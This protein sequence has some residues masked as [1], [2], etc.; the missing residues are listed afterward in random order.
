MTWTPSIYL[1]P[2]ALHTMSPTMPRSV[3]TTATISSCRTYLWLSLPLWREVCLSPLRTVSLPMQ[4]RLSVLHCIPALITIA[5][6]VPHYAWAKGL[7][8]PYSQVCP[9]MCSADSQSSCQRYE[10]QSRSLPAWC[11]SWSLAKYCQASNHDDRFHF[12]GDNLQHLATTESKS[13]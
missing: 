10:R 13:K 9:C 6:S 8:V 12:Y 1:F 11:Y 4:T 2:S 3:Q 7:Q 5:E